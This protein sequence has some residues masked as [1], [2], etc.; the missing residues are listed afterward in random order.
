[1][2][3]TL[4]HLT[5]TKGPLGLLTLEPHPMRGA[6]LSEVHARPFLPVRTPARMLHFGFLTDPAQALAA[7]KALVA[8]CEARGVDG[9]RDYSKHFSVALSDAT[10]RFEQHSEFTTYTWELAKPDTDPFS[11]PAGSLAQGMAALPQPGPH[12]L[13]VDLHLVKEAPTIELETLFDTASLAA[14]WVDSNRAVAAT[15]FKPG[16]DGF[17]RILVLDR[18]L[19][20]ASAGALVQRLLEI[21]TY[22]ML[23]LMG[24]PET[25]ALAPSIKRIEDALGRVAGAMT[26]TRGLSADHKLLDELTNLAAELEAGAAVTAFRFGAS[27]AY[28]TIVKQRLVTIGEQPYRGLPSIAQFLARRMDPAMRTCMTLE[29]RQANLAVKLARAANLL[30]TRVDVEIEQQ[31]RDLLHSMNER[32]RLQLLLQQTVEGLSVAAVSYYIVGLIAYIAKG[33]KD[34]NVIA[35]E[36]GLVS[37]ASVPLVLIFM[38]MVIRRVRRSHTP[39]PS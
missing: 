30:R 33:L 22:R 20:A 9:P 18:S 2:A 13:S 7:R 28:D 10:L 8:F 17:V 5:E 25:Q 24:L 38:W 19:T 12:L 34:A 36:P 21:E 23:A 15:D 11:R 3:D 26:E 32:T 14:S 37:A 16:S 27:R 31:N 4:E 1:M 29:E 39:D 35:L 6:V